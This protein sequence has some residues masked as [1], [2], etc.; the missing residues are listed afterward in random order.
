[1]IALDGGDGRQKGGKDRVLQIN[2]SLRTHVFWPMLGIG[3]E[4]VQP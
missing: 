1:M 2:C 4:H 3:W